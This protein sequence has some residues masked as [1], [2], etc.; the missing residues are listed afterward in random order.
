MR[1][2]VVAGVKKEIESPIQPKVKPMDPE[3]DRDRVFPNEISAEDAIKMTK[4]MD[5]AWT[6]SQPAALL[7]AQPK[8]GWNEPEKKK[9]RDYLLAKAQQEAQLV[10][11]LNDQ[12]ELQRQQDA[13]WANYE[14]GAA[15][16]RKA[17]VYARMEKLIAQRNQFQKDMDQVTEQINKLVHEYSGYRAAE[18][19]KNG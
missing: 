3:R 16:R 1:Y 17:E 5:Q 9:I 11:E 4:E 14:A 12:R 13:W 19:T 7:E 10:R 8:E 2:S 15:E 6:A 18:E